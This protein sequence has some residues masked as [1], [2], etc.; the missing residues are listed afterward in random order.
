MGRELSMPKISS[1][2]KTGNLYNG[3]S[4]SFWFSVVVMLL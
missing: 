4:F 1:K 2:S 3:I